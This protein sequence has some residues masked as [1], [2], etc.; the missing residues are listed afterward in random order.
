MADLFFCRV[1]ALLQPGGVLAPAVVDGAG[2]FRDL[3]TQGVTWKEEVVLKS[4][5][6]LASR[7][8]HTHAGPTSVRATFKV[9]LKTKSYELDYRVNALIQAPSGLNR[10]KA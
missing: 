9:L 2:N 3:T 1:G 8:H 5:G 4:Y 10:R 6:A 7:H